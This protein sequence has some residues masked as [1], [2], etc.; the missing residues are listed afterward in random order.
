[1]KFIKKFDELNEGKDRYDIVD[2]HVHAGE[3]NLPQ[4]YSTSKDYMTVDNTKVQDMGVDS[5]SLIPPPGNDYTY[6]TDENDHVSDKEVKKLMEPHIK[7]F[8]DFGFT[9]TS[10]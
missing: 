10:K 3:V 4:F 8:N 7:K 9:P 2:N 1:M 6:L 5:K